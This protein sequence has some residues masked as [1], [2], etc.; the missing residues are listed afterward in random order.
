MRLDPDSV[1][2]HAARVLTFGLA[3]LLAG[4]AGG[5]EEDGTDG[6]N[7]GG[8]VT[9]HDVRCAPGAASPVMPEGLRLTGRYDA[10]DAA[11]IRLGWQGAGVVATV[12]GPEIAVRLR[13]EGDTVFF[14]SVVDGAP[15]ARIRV[16][17][18]A[19]C[20]AVLASGLP[21][22]AHVVE[23]YRDTEG[24]QP[25]AAFL[26]FTKGN[27]GPAPEWSGRRLEIVGDSISA[28]YGNLGSEPHPGWVANP[29]CHWTAENSSWFQTYAARAGR[30][31][32]AEVSTVALSG[33]G[34]YRSNTGS[35]TNVLGTVYGHA[36]GSAATAA[37]TFP[38]APDAVLVNLGTN[39]AWLDS[40]GEAAFDA[41]AYVA[42]GVD[43]VAKIRAHAPEAWVFLAIGPMLNDPQLGEVKAAQAALVAQLTDAGD[44]KVEAFDFGRQALGANGEIPSGCDWHPSVAEHGRMAAILET[45]LRARLGW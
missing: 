28:G 42:A 30:A 43:L 6:E 27:A 7:G 9:A 37:W 25:V 26:G 8:G 14:Q 41:A 33:W 24:N 1:P 19:D 3:L 35:A 32:G 44:A 21:D 23:L 15:A 45:R 36:L 18:G 22:A 40:T 17:A 12:S 29:A 2:A 16:D 38:V 34:L 10:S 11:A 5:G 39:D 31:L 20:T 13:A 4:C